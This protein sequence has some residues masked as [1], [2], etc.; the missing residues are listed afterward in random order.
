M[1]VALSSPLFDGA[2]IHRVLPTDD[3]L[4]H[5]P[6]LNVLV[7]L[8]VKTQFFGNC[9]EDHTALLLF[10]RTACPHLNKSGNHVISRTIARTCHFPIG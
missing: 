3:F 10:H 8:N 2:G 7:L 5:L 4:H 6:I 9:A 1:H